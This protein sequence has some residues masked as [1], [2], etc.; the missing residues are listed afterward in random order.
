MHQLF[1]VIYWTA[2]TED[3][4]RAVLEGIEAAGWKFDGKSVCGAKPRTLY[5]QHTAENR[6]RMKYIPSLKR[7]VQN[8]LMVDDRTRSFLDTPRQAILI[9]RWYVDEKEMDLSRE[10]LYSLN[11]RK[12]P[13]DYKKLPSI[14]KFRDSAVQDR[15]LEE[16]REMLRRC[17][18]SN[19][20]SREMD[21]Y[22]PDGYHLTD[23]LLSRSDSIGA[24][25]PQRR[26]KPVPPL[27][28]KVY[29]GSFKKL[30][31]ALKNFLGD[32]MAIVSPNQKERE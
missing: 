18:K 4:G 22:R 21:F 2:G 8:V 31:P 12:K 32:P 23:N 3:Y 13:V 20:P 7:P 14:P 17:A 28:R 15:A 26:E 11:G 6:D 5:R 19:N 10:D 25:V 9:P 16:M 1:E 29:L 30:D 27:N 24:Y